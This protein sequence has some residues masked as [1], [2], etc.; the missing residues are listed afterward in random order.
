MGFLAS[1]EIK[2]MECAHCL[3]VEMFRQ[4]TG[5]DWKRILEFVLYFKLILFS[6]D[7]KVTD[8]ENNNKKRNSLKYFIIIRQLICKDFY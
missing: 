5:G 1:K 3:F 7:F 6:S 8:V 2:R 4:V